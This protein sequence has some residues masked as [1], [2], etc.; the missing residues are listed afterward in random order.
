MTPILANWAS[1]YSRYYVKYA[2]DAWNNMTPMQY[3]TIL[4]CVAVFGWVLMKSNR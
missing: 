3:G 4:I 2:T 1:R